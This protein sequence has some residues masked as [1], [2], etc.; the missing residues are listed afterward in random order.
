MSRLDGADVP[1]L[2]YI[3]QCIV[4]TLARLGVQT[5]LGAYEGML[6]V[7]ACTESSF[8]HELVEFARPPL[9]RRH[10]ST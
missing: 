10:V 2:S 8:L 9:L 7:G 6:D 5:M 4:V 1:L 3:V